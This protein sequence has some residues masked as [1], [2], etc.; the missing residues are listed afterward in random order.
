M[1]F[2]KGND[3]GVKFSKDNQPDNRGR[4]G[5]S[6]TE[7]L[8]D[9]GEAKSIHFSIEVTGKEGKKKLKTGTV[10]SETDLNE[11][12]ANLLWA[13]AIQGNHKA[14]KEILDRV[15]GRP[16]Q[17]IDMK[18]EDTTEQNFDLTKLTLEEKIQMLELMRKSETKQEN[19]NS[20]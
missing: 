6:T 12:L 10:E 13:D 1:K 2:Q 3:L 18:T 14:M 19:K 11:L 9:L 8:R 5:K 7:Y 16:N 4:K 15:E 17:T 20:D